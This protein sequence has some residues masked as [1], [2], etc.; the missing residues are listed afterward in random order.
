[1]CKTQWVLWLVAKAMFCCYL[2]YLKNYNNLT[3]G[4]YDFHGFIYYS[5]IACFI[6]CHAK[7]VSLET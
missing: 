3:P 7:I 5:F 2:C 4:L 1:M 6:I